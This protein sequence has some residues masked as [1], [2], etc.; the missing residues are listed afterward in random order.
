MTAR[1]TLYPRLSLCVCVCSPMRR[2][3]HSGCSDQAW[4]DGCR[5][6]CDGH[7][8]WPGYE[9]YGSTLW[10]MVQ[11]INDIIV[12]DWSVESALRVNV[13]IIYR[14]IPLPSP[15]L[16]HAHFGDLMGLYTDGLI[17]RLKIMAVTILLAFK[18][19]KQEKKKKTQQI[20][21][22]TPVRLTKM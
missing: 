21:A 11:H 9:S 3:S 1:Y 19:K 8:D 5:H 10:N 16:I 18:E 14:W 2:K 13:N 6:W 12:S 20:N 15:G 17:H 4:S 7:A 22:K